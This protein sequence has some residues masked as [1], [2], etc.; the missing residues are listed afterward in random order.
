VIQDALL[1]TVAFI[2][3]A[4][5]V[6]YQAQTSLIYEKFLGRAPTILPRAGF[7]L[8]PPHVS[9]LLKNTI[10]TCAKFFKGARNCAR[11]WKRKRCLRLSPRASMKG[12]KQS[13][14]SSRGC[15][16][17]SASWTRLWSAR[18]TRPLKKCSTSSMHCARRQD[19]PKDFAPASSIRM[20]MNRKLAVPQ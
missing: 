1:P 5:E 8:V 19:A 18:W 3:G 20:R 10:W 6:A 12:N 2:A 16:N 11:A 4:A 15:A 13:R 17:L 9:N 14:T 7:T